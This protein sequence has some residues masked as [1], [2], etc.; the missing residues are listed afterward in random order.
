M[1]EEAQTTTLHFL[2]YWRV[3]RDRKEVIL[4]VALLT[5]VTGTA[6]TLMMPQK[7]TAVTQLEVLEDSMDVDPFYDRQSSRLGYNPFFLMTQQKIMTSRPILT[8]V[9]RNLNLQRVWGLQLNEDK[10][11]ITAELALQILTR[12]L[13]VEQDRDTTLMNI[14]VKSEDPKLAA[15]IAN[16][17]ANVYRDRRLN[18]KRR[19]I[20]RAIDA[21][22]NEVRKQQERVEEAEM[23]L[24]RIR[25]EQGIALIGKGMA[26]YRI[27]TASLSMLQSERSAARV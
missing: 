14:S 3:I 12:N 21:M 4:A 18:A 9:I 22:S 1:A 19:E 27:E 13:R 6:Y 17:I 25:Q 7:F 24:E 26:S 20:Q 8:Q 10:S 23:E 2:D 5:I 15:D 11:P 16:E